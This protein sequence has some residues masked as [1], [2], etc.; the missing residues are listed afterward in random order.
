MLTSAMKPSDVEYPPDT[1]NSPVD[2]SSSSTLR[3]TRSGAEP[4]SVRIRTFL[5]YDKFFK[6]R[7][8]RLT[9]ARL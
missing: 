5:K 6:R 1:E 2:V 4:G 3:M 9:S 8:A 7:S